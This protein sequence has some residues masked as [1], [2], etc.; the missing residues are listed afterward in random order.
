[1]IQAMPVLGFHFG[2]TPDDVWNL[3]VEEWAAYQRAIDQIEKEAKR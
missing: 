2:L 3:T 1:M